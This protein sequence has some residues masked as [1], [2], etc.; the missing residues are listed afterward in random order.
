MAT[1][2]GFSTFHSD[3]VALPPEITLDIL[4]HALAETILS[5]MGGGVNNR[6][7][8]HA[9]ASVS[10]ALRLLYLSLPSTV[11]IRKLSPNRYKIGE[12]LAF[13]DL[14]TM[15]AFFTGGPGRYPRFFRTIRCLVVSYLDD[16]TVSWW[17]GSNAYAYE[18]FELLHQ[19][20]GD[21][22][23]ERL[24]I[25]FYGAEAIRSVD[26]PGIWSLLKI[27]GLAH[28]ELISER[29]AISRQVRSHLTA[30]TRCKKLFPW[31]PL[32]LENPGPRE[33]STHVKYVDDIPKWRA[34]F[35]WL[36]SRYKFL[37]DRETI[38]RRCK[39]QRQ[40]RRRWPMLSKR[41]KRGPKARCVPESCGN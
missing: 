35:D 38:A 2:F 28:L 26:D 22:S 39:R 25:H 4:R 15:A 17:R 21:M 31:R 11:E 41:K 24:R 32:G 16:G 27:R 37:Q 29:R 5:P 8:H 12:V 1:K 9:I 13:D 33:W 36:D 10:R 20:W 19:S 3:E 40:R 34:E 23:I 14:S 6:N 7:S 30:R 18:A